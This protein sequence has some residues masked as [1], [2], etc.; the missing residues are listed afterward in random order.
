MP[1]TPE[2][3][4][5]SVQHISMSRLTLSLQGRRKQFLFGQAK[6]RE[7]L[8]AHKARREILHFNDIHDDD[9]INSTCGHV[10][11]Y[12]ACVEPVQY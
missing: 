7:K 6:Y 9:V 1:A 8:M 4:T 3:L 11:A 10:R 5:F 2:D 12:C